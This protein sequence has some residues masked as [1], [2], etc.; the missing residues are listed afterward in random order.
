MRIERRNAAHDKRRDCHHH[1]EPNRFEFSG[2][3]TERANHTRF[4][5]ARPC[6]HHPAKCSP[7]P[8]LRCKMKRNRIPP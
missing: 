7:N 3:E 4:L 1:K 8:D 5:R 6:C 2:H